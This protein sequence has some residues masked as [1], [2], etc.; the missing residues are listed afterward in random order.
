[1]DVQRAISECYRDADQL[2]LKRTR[3]RLKYLMAEWGPEKFTQEVRKKL[4]WS[5]DPA[6][7]GFEFSDETYRDHLG[8]NAQKQPGLH[9]IGVCILSG[10]ITD[11]NMRRAADVADKY[12]AG[13]IR[14]TNVQNFLIPHIATEDLEGAKADLAAAGFRVGCSQHPARGNYLHRH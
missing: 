2:R 9:W 7:P 3:A 13:E 14:L 5:P 10:R 4:S 11:D 8:V 6:A 1:M 12:G